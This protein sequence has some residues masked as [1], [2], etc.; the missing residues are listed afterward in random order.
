MRSIENE[1]YWPVY[2]RVLYGY[3]MIMIND[4]H[5]TEAEQTVRY[6]EECPVT[7]RCRVLYGPVVKSSWLILRF[8]LVVFSFFPLIN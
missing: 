4:D 1:C 8:S 5:A 3:S 6:T 7:V 2:S